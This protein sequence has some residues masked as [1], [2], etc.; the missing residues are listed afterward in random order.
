MATKRSST[1]GSNPLTSST[2]KSLKVDEV[3]VAIEKLPNVSKKRSVSLKKQAD[4]SKKQGSDKKND[5]N[6]PKRASAKKINPSATPARPDDVLPTQTSGMAARVKRSNH[7]TEVLFANELRTE[8]TPAAGKTVQPPASSPAVVS[9]PETSIA[10]VAP[11]A[12][13]VTDMSLTTRH[14]EAMAIVKTWSQW[15]VVAGM[16]PVPVLDII[17]L[18]GAQIKMIQLL[19]KHYNIPFEKKVA[20]AVATGLIGGTLTSAVATGAT[21]I[22][23]K[24]IPVV[25]Q[26]FNW[27]VEPVLSFGSTY[28]IG[29]TFVQHFDSNGNLKSFK[30]EEMKDFATEQFLKGKKLFQ[31]KKNAAAA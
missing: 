25:G 7:E 26:I 15:S 16:T 22:V 23:M 20:V 1:I 29:A 14:R 27:T 11:P 31:S 5:P 8:E 28:A 30:S 6:K 12:K 3:K 17:A 18:S 2:A 21:R 9:P 13:V 4:S 10:V 19:C 24:N